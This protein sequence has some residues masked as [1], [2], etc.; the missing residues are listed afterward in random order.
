MY[1][2]MGLSIWCSERRTCWTNEE[3]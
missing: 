1:Q 3:S 2:E